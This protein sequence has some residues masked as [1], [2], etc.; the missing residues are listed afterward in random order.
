MN[1]SAAQ[2]LNCLTFLICYQKLKN[3]VKMPP[4][5]VCFRVQDFMN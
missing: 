3:T 2:A 5:A 1:A 4:C